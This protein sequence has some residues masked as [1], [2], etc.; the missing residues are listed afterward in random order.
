MVEEGLGWETH[1]VEYVPFPRGYRSWGTNIL[2][3]HYIN[4]I[5]LMRQEDGADFIYGAIYSSLGDYSISP[6]LLRALLEMWDSQTNTFLFP[7]GERTVTLLDLH[8]MA[9]LPVDG[10]Y[11]E[12]YIPRT[13]ELDPS[14]LL[15]PDSLSV[16]LGVWDKLAIDGEVKFQA[17]CDYFYNRH[18]GLITL[19]SIHEEHIFV[20]A[21]L[22]LW[23]CCFVVVGSGPHIW[24][25][26]LVMAAWMSLGWHFS[27]A[28]PAL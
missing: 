7:Y 12:E 19:S 21:F 15:Y 5:H 22:A 3:N 16:L 17:W 11:Y 10:E 26:V 25:G 14:L 28:P 6:P 20:A 18:Q 24:R 9:G 1:D 23:L 27:L 2:K 4:Y 13:H 8:H